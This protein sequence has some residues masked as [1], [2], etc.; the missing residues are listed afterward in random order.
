M[1]HLLSLVI[2][3]CLVSSTLPAEVSYR[4][5]HPSYNPGLFSVYHSVVGALDLYERKQLHGLHVDFA[6]KGLY[7]EA[8]YG[9]N[10]WEYYFKP[11]RLGKGNGA[12]SSLFTDK[13]ITQCAHAT[14]YHITH[15]RANM[16]IKKYIKP[17]RELRKKIDDFYNAFFKGFYVIGIHYRGTN[18]MNNGNRVSHDKALHEIQKAITSVGNQQWKLFVATDEEAFYNF[19]KEKFPNRV[20]AIKASRSKDGTPVHLENYKASFLKGQEAV[21]DCYLLARCDLLLKTC[22]NLSDISTKLNPKLSVVHLN[23]CN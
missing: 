9:L 23:H 12:N 16:L 7:Y 19:L 3:I 11:I 21:L 13:E 18:Q 15:L 20:L 4:M 17:K 6:D 14:K 2:M 10:W 1:F 5:P 8:A 22:S